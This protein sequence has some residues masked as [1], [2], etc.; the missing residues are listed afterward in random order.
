MKEVR[1][2]VIGSALVTGLTL[3]YLWRRYLKKLSEWKEVAEVDKLFVHPVK[4]CRGIEVKSFVAQSK[5]IYAEGTQ[6][7]DRS[8]MMTH[9]NGRFATIRQFPNMV[10]ITPTVVAENKLM[11][12]A[13]GMDPIEVATPD[14]RIVK[15][16]SY[17]VFGTSCLGVD[18]GDEVA[19]WL[20]DYTKA[21][22]TR[23]VYHSERLPSRKNPM[24]LEFSHL[25]VYA[26]EPLQSMF[27]DD[28]PFNLVSQASLDMLNTKLDENHQINERFFRPN[29]LL[30]GKQQF[31]IDITV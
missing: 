22:N 19:K 31:S 4:S 2:V 15:A 21:N 29:V 27:Q 8:F 10:L 28:S 23:L 1:G 3:L 11:L 13:P 18:C 17:K 20:Q 26:K 9:E 16:S 6:I 14:H 12:N 7:G 24:L 5:G 25:G 30:K